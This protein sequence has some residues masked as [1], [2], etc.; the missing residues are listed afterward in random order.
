MAIDVAALLTPL[1]DDAPCGDDLWGTAPFEALREAFNQA[2]DELVDPGSVD[3]DWR[4]LARDAEA[5]ATGA[6]DIRAAGYVA[7]SAARAGS[8]AGAADGV[9][10]LAGLLETFWE[11]VDPVPETDDPDDL[12]ER[13]SAIRALDARSS[14]ITPL[15]EA[16]ILDS[17]RYGSFSGADLI[18]FRKPATED[19][20][21]ADGRQAF[22]EALS[23]DP[24]APTAAIASL[25]RITAAFARISKAFRDNAPDG[26]GPSFSASSEAIAALRGILAGFAVEP[27]AEAAPAGGD[28]VVSTGAPVG[29]ASGGGGK[30]VGAIN[31]RDDVIRALDAICD[32]YDRCEPSSPVSTALRRAKGW[33]KMDFLSVL[34]EINPDAVREVRK[35]LSPRSEQE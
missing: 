20:D 15:R 6:R 27:P 19:F 30:S 12:L 11:G 33:V 25:D 24:A 4:G 18:S 16:T 31:S 23:E 10:L 13:V 2:D 1:S 7:R 26:P 21:P 35:V 8:L 3:L 17:R 5:L 29:A 34:A 22:L 9:E 14:F 28:A 32:Y